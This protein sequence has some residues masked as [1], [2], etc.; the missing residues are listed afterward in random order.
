[1]SNKKPLLQFTA[2]IV[3]LLVLKAVFAE[4]VS[5]VMPQVEEIVVSGFRDKSARNLNT[6]ITVLNQDDIDSAS[7]GRRFQTSALPYTV[8]HSPAPW[9][10]P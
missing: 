5:Q 6:S 9:L 3:C 4:D 1:M 10:A 2:A 7:G 8:A